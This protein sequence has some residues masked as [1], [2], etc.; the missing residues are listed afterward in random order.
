MFQAGRRLNGAH[1]QLL[2][3]PAEGS[4]GR[5]GFVIGKKQ[6]ASAVDRNYLRRLLREAVR[7]RRPALDAFDIVLRLRTSCPPANLAGLLREA[8]ELLS[9]LTEARGR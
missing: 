1:L 3:S 2:A 8:S 9:D 6:L 4:I 7:Q 5:V